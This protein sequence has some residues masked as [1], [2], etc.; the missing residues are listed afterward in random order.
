M[1][2]PHRVAAVISAYNPPADLIE[3]V[4]RLARQV[5][6][7]IVVDDGSPADVSEVLQGLES[8][9]AVVLKQGSNTGIAA[10][11]NAG[12]RYAAESSPDFFLTLDQDSELDPDYVARALEAFA[13]ATQQGVPVGMICAES[14]NKQPVMLQKP[15]VPFPEAFDPM[16]SG[17]LIPA[18]TFDAAGL[19]EEDLFIDCVDSEFTARIREM[20][21]KAIIAPGCNISHAVG[22]SRPMLVGRWH[23]TVGGQKRFVHSHAPFRVYYITRNGLVMYRRYLTRQPVWVLRRIGLEIV[24]YGV[25]VVYGPHR[26]RQIAAIAFGIRDALTGRMGRISAKENAVVSPRKKKT[27]A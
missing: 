20:G 23:V 9:G 22:D 21:L 4:K 1:T 26:L 27:A 15:G 12:I 2:S 19:L 25:R 13:G 5:E 6:R 14:H 17:T 18:A 3:K 7:I 10:A 11:L 8:A 16:Q 24:F